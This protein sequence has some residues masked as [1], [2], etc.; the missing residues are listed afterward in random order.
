[1]AQYG[2]YHNTDECIGC[3]ACVVACKDKYNLPYGEKYRRVYDYGGGSWKV[4]DN[5]VMTNDDF[6]I[7]NVSI[8]CNHCTTPACLASCPVGAIIKREDGIVYIN[9]AECIGC[10]ACIGACPYGAPYM[11]AATGLAHKCDFCMD[12]IDNGEDPACILAC[13]MRCL[14][15]GE[16]EELR[17]EYGTLSAVA[18]VTEEDRTGPNVVFKRHRL[19]P[20]GKLIGEILNPDEEIVSE[21]NVV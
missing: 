4:D 10:N 17:A 14:K 12:K 9:T 20:D 3:N 1:M 15:Y 11:S 16:I 18:P 19:N 2:F 8:A 13:P 21:T 6:F 5:G 7:Y